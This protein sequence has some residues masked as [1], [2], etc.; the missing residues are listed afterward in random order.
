MFKEIESAVS[1]YNMF[2]GKKHVIV[3]LSGGADSMCLL[4]F[5]VTNSEKFGISVS[6]A[7]LNHCL[8]GAESERDHDFVSDQCGKLGVELF[9]KRCDI[10][11]IAK[12]RKIGLEE[13]GREERYR[14]FDDLIRDDE[15]VV[16]TAHTASDNAETV[17][18]NITRGCGMEGLTGIP[19]VRGKIVR[20]LIRCSRARIE[21]YCELNDVPFVT[22]STN[23]SDEYNRNKIRLSV[24]PELKKINPSVENSINRLSGIVSKNLEYIRK[25]TV[26]EFER[27][28]NDKGLS[29]SELKKCDNNILPDVIKLSVEKYFDISAEKKH[30]DI[31]EK[32][33][34]DSQGAIELRKNKAVKAVGDNLVFENILKNDIEVPG[35]EEIAFRSGMR[36]DYNNKIYI[37]SPKKNIFREDNGKINKKLL[38]Q[39]IS[40]DIISCDTVVRNRKSGDFFRPVGRNCTKTLKKLFI[41]MKIPREKRD[42]LLVLANGSNVLWIEGIGPSEDALP[43]NEKAEY[44]TVDTEVK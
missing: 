25:K 8:R 7:H 21:E 40:C 20:P 29:I 24:L 42:K 13:C 36:I 14:F 41:E 32:I 2:E 16:A 39:C 9:T 44:F 1:E 37:F 27:C 23:L 22:D 34:K 18:M 30:I 43:Q 26:S 33:I 19:P 15:T 5:L 3:A 10:S 38:N 12:E 31:I 11:G 28:K 4:H 17:L 35:F 6:A